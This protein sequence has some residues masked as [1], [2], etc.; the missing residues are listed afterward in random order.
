[1]SSPS[2]ILA[3]GAILLCPVYAADRGD[4]AIKDGVITWT[5]SNDQRLKID[6]RT[7]CADLWV[8]PDG[9]LIAFIALDH[10]VPHHGPVLPWEQDVVM[11]DSSSVYI[12]RRADG[13]IPVLAVS[14]SYRIHLPGAEYS[15]ILRS[16]SVSQDGQTVFYTIPYGG[17]TSLL[18]SK[19]LRNGETRAV[20]EMI[21][22]CPLWGG[23]QSGNLLL[24]R[25]HQGETIEYWCELRNQVGQLTILNTKDCML[26]DF[27]KRWTATNGSL[28]RLAA[29]DDSVS[30]R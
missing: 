2:T 23:K 20:V 13:F 27:S 12:A 16:P 10:T 9:G 3:V 29:S 15:S 11:I 30:P 18:M 25:R 24:T 6:V 7:R 28:C 21:E 1:M 8:S 22:Y 5:D 19:S 4:P 26:N 17:A 14:G